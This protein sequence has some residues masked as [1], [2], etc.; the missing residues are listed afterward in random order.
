MAAAPEPPF[1]ELLWT[2]AVARL[3][4]GPSMNIQAPPNLTPGACLPTTVCAIPCLGAATA[5]SSQPVTYFCLL[6]AL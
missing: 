4:F 2:V 3:L 5:G 1:G 6:F